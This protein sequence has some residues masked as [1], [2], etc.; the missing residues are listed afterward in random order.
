LNIVKGVTFLKTLVKSKSIISN[1]NSF[2]RRSELRNQEPF[3]DTNKDWNHLCLNQTW[4]IGSLNYLFR[5]SRSYTPHY[6]ERYYYES[7]KQR[8]ELLKE[9]SPIKQEILQNF[10]IPYMKQKHLLRFLTKEEIMLNTHYGRTPE[11]LNRIADFFYQELQH[12]FPLTPS[13]AKDYVRIRVIDETFIGFQREIKT[14]SYLRRRYPDY[15]IRE[16][17]SDMDSLYA[18][19]CEVYKG[20]ALL[21]ALQIKSPQYLHS[22]LSFLNSVKRYN[23]EKNELYTRTFGVPVL[24]VFSNSNGFIKNREI[25]SELDQL[26]QKK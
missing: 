9:L 10:T 13:L 4:A 18:I 22:K 11:E 3:H 19:D 20:N 2:A 26:I 6:W 21:V 24:Y 23:Q 1:Q 15:T 16:A 5:E 12:K 17:S 14:I 25:L 8:L 7:G